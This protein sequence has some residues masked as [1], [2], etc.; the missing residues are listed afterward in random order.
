MHIGV[1]ISPPRWGVISEA[2]VMKF[3]ILTGL[4]DVINFVKFGYDRLRG[5]GLVSSQI[6]GFF[7]HFGIRP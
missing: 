4:D 6:L 2:I 7:L 5:W 1:F 3:G